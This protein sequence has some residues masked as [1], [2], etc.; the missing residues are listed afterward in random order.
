MTESQLRKPF[1]VALD[2]ETTG[3]DPTSDVILEI[4]FMIVDRDLEL[5]ANWSRVVN[6]PSIRYDTVPGEYLPPFGVH[7][8]VVEMHSK[9][10]LWRDS[11]KSTH[12]IRPALIEAKQWLKANLP[13]PVPELNG[14]DKLPLLGSTI[15][16][17]KSFLAEADYSLLDLFSYRSIDVS[18]VKLLY[19]EWVTNEYDYATSSAP[20][21]NKMHRV[22]PDII[23]TLAELDFYRHSL[24]GIERDIK[25]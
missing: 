16:F 7:Q 11:Y 1:A 13:V 12:A 8:A 20:K 24:F 17:D 4:G 21:G 6:W 18:S 10:N 22:I 14:T 15:G 3:L 2:I 9:N 5:V 25:A 19:N 23:D